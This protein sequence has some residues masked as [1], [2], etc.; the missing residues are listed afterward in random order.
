MTVKELSQLYWL[1][2][3]IE[4]DQKRLYKLEGEIQRLKNEAAELERRASSPSGPN[5]TGMPKAP[6]PIDGNKIE[7]YVAEIIEKEQLINQKIAMRDACAGVIRSKQL[8]CM[9]E[10]TKLETYIASIPDSFLRQIFTLR[11]INGL[12]WFQVAMH[13]ADG[14]DAKENVT[15]DSV[16]K[17]C[18]RYLKS[19]NEKKS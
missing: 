7:R 9:T 2:R 13:L 16:K 19:E 6:S 12:P 4:L 8:L 1:N 11:F 18:Y 10:R 17:Q 15:E 3:E 5:L 14:D